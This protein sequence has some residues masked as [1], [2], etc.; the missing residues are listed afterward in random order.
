MLDCQLFG[1]YAWG[2]HFTN[3]LLHCTA[4]VLLFLLL[5]SMTGSLWRSAF[6]AAV[7]A[8]HPLRA[9]S[10]AWVSERKDVLSAF[11]F[12]LTLWA[13]VRYTRGPFSIVRY[14]AVV[15]L[16]T[17]GLLSKDMLVTLPF[18][19]LL[20]DYWPLGRLSGPGRGR[21][22]RL[23]AEKIPLIVLA[24]GSCAVTL[25]VP[26]KISLDCRIPFD[27]RLENAIVSYVIYL[28]QLVWP[29][30]LACVYPN[31]V[32]SLPFWQ[33]AGAAML[34]P[35]ITGAA[36]G[37]RKKQPA[38][39]VGWFWFLGMMVPVIGIMQIS[40][41]AHADRYT[42]LPSIGALII[43]AWGLKAISDRIGNHGKLMVKIASVA[44]ISAL[45]WTSWK[46]AGFWE[47]NDTLFSRAISVTKDNYIAYNHLSYYYERVGRQNDAIAYYQKSLGLHPDQGDTHNR[48]GIL[49]S[50][51]GLTDEA[52]AHFQTALKI[53]PRNSL[54]H[55][56]MGIL[57]AKMGKADEA[58]AHYVK[59]LEINPADNAIYN[60]MGV[61]LAQLGR[62]DEAIVNFRKALALKPDAV[63]AL[64]NCAFALLQKGQRADAIS[65]VQNA[66]AAAEAAGNGVRARV[67]ELIL[68]RLNETDASSQTR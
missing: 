67:L 14:S 4:A 19:L 44:A 39:M 6:V 2:H 21:A 18:V 27:L 65:L 26:E 62:I 37:Y 15:L 29:S 56:N 23:V 32:H 36:V 38:F 45:C 68:A 41:Y 55:Y 61:L 50:K 9:E 49:L 12:M 40:Y 7:F 20:L 59:A 43:A 34:L 63:E 51:A 58:L 52:M 48:L 10:V 53:N 22:L 16:Y 24:A 11:F 42:Y 47:N 17:L 33:V 54:A 35:A 3:I 8:L 25:L 28:R 31:P 13:Y 66:H 46:Q 5:R 57:F 64:Q 1:L 30:G 60:N